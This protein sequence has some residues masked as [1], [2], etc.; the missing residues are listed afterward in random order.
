MRKCSRA[1]I[2]VD[3]QLLQALLVHP[4][5]SFPRGHRM[6]PSIFERRMTRR[7]SLHTSPAR[8]EGCVVGWGLQVGGSACHCL[9]LC[10]W[11]MGASQ[12]TAASRTCPREREQARARALTRC[13]APGVSRVS[14]HL[15]LA[16]RGRDRCSTAPRE[17]SW[18][19]WGKTG[20][21]PLCPPS[22]CSEWTC[23][24]AAECCS[25]QRNSW[26]G[27]EVLAA[28]AAGSAIGSVGLG[29]DVPHVQ[30][31]WP[32]DTVWWGRT[33][34]HFLGAAYRRAA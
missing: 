4:R 28:L 11:G 2:V 25:P 1:L 16:W 10:A 6:H 29:G 32:R 30:A 26:G 18:G 9:K 21:Q 3:K 27:E 14:A 17:G 5:C 7:D 15:P 33:R 24:E 20:L 12:C 31:I 22:P 8:L 34:P 19:R 23:L 13:A